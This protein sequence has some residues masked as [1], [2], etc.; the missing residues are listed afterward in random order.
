MASNLKVFLS[1]KTAAAALKGLG[2]DNKKIV[3][4]LPFGDEANF[5]SFRNVPN[6]NLLCFDQPNVF[7]LGNS[8]CWV[9]LK[10]DI[11]SFKNMVALWN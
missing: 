10:K 3:L 1:T 7:D 5:V 8:D 6:V 11:D 4:L 9:F 2:I